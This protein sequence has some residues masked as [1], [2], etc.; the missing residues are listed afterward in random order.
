MKKIIAVMMALAM[1]MSSFGA[2]AEQESAPVRTDLN[3]FSDLEPET[4]DVDVSVS[5]AILFRNIYATL[6][7]LNAYNQ[8]VPELAESYSVND[9]Y[10]E[11]TFVLKDNIFFSDGT[12]ITAED[13]KYTYDRGIETAIDY[14]Y[15]IKSVETPDS[16]TVVITLNEPSNAFMADMVSEHMSVMSKAAI[17][18][19]M[20]VANCPKITSGAYYVTE[21]DKD[22]H[23]IHLQANPYYLNGEPAIKT[24]TICYKLDGPAYEAILNGTIDYVTNIANDSDEIA[25]MRAADSIELMPYDNNSWNF[26]AL[27]QLQ[28]WYADVN[29][30]RAIACALD[31][32]YIIGIALDGQGTPAPLIITGAISGYL[33]GFSDSP[34]NLKQAKEYM[35]ASSYPDGFTMTLEISDTTGAKVAEAVKTLLQEINIDVVIVEEDGNL[36]VNNALDGTYDATFLSYSMYSGNISHA[37]PLYSSGELHISRGNDTEIGDLMQRSLAVD[38][39]ERDALLSQAYTMMRDQW[40][41]IGLY[42]ITVRDAKALNLKLTE[43]IV[44][45]KYI[46]SNMYWE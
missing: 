27:N 39:D 15:A 1:L 21:W 44:S 31:L 6:Y 40:P 7:R 20:D 24:V 38:G 12:P 16:K 34:Y 19:G 29:V 11:Y 3:V 28:P 5:T 30:R 26:L 10:T 9:D 22:N 46:L 8:M 13:V 42:W 4:L 43:P 23:R 37:I 33:P 2:F 14:F 35:A 32:E 41:Y 45:E 36:L 17:E 18:G 25:Y